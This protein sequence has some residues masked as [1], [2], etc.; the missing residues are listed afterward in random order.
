[1]EYCKDGDLRKFLEKN[2]G[3]LPEEF[4]VEILIDLLSAFVELVEK[5]M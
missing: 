2:G 4:A 1:M 5:G 3:K